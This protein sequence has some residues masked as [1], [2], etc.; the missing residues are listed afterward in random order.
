MK[1]MGAVSA[2]MLDYMERHA[3]GVEERC[4]HPSRKRCGLCGELYCPA[5]KC[6]PWH[7]E[8]CREAM[9]P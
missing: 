3:A 2:A 1:R 5:D 7:V 4:A 9:R 6:D 8:M